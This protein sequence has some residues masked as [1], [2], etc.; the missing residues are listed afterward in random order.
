MDGLMPVDNRWPTE[1]A[2]VASDSVSCEVIGDFLVLQYFLAN[3]QCFIFH[4]LL[5]SDWEV[6]KKQQP[7]EYALGPF[8]MHAYH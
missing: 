3:A 4:L 2:A 6:G 7:S 8:L 5:D 1:Q